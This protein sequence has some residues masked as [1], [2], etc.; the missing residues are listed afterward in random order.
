MPTTLFWRIASV[1]F[2]VAIGA[3]ISVY[4]LHDW[5]H[6]S[7]L[8]G[9]NIDQPFADAV[10]TVMV[11]AA[12][13]L[14]Q[15]LVSVMFYRDQ[16]YGLKTEQEKLDQHRNDYQ[17]VHEEVA[18]ELMAVP[19][20][21]DVLRT[22]LNRVTEQTEKAAYD[23]TERLMNIDQVMEELNGFVTTSSNE[24]AELCAFAEQRIEGNQQLIVN[25]RSYIEQRINEAQEDQR[26]IMEVV[27]QARS[28]S[29]LIELIRNIASQTNLLA[30]NAAIE[31]ARAGEAGRGFAVVADEVRK[32][33]L[34]TERAVSQINDGI[35]GVAA[36]IE[37][38]FED[39]LSHSNLST[40]RQALE[41][42]ANHLSELGDSYVGIVGFQSQVIHSIRQAS[43][44][45]TAQFMDAVASVQFQDVTRQ[46]L[47][48]TA[49]ALGRLDEHAGSMAER[50][51]QSDNP[52]FTYRPLAH[53]LDE[54][55]AKYVMDSQRQDHQRATG[56]ASSS[57]T[58]A[59]NDL[60]NVELF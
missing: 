10:G 49:L 21:N 14:G 36:T 27:G 3:G 47:E 31:A 42:F 22:Q 37:K 32:L 9:L 13:F 29:S 54:I 52:D 51:R 8:Y 53:H 60:P 45:L 56:Q 1:F 44:K 12:A 6:N 15:R 50:L 16:M 55:Y 46:Q 59:K 20:F 35:Q 28:L 25:M 18:K 5:F 40:E 4:A 34:E 43:D 2:F 11:V 33:S 17:A 19:T 48:Q 57:H 39:K 26:R 7:F 58:T 30:L 24:S 23:I 38:Q 41:T